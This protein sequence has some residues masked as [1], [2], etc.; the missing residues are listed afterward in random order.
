MNIIATAYAGPLDT[1]PRL[2][3][4]VANAVLAVL[5]I[6]AGL[7]VLMILIGGIM[8]ITAAGDHA[9]MDLAKKTVAGSVIGLVI[10]A[11]SLVIVQSIAKL[12]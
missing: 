3:T 11:L 7:A 5:A 4:I 12:V 8:Y 9:R 1:A 2:T 6:V 10:A